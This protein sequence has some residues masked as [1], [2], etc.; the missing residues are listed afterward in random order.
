MAQNIGTLLGAPIRPADSLDAFPS[1]YAN[2]GKGGFY[3]VADLTARNAI[4]ADRREIGMCVKVISENKDYELLRGITNDNW[5]EKIYG[6]DT[7][8]LAPINNPTFTGSVIVPT[9]TTA[10]QAVNFGQLE[11]TAIPY[12]GTP[13]GKPITGDLEFETGTIIK[14]YDAGE[15]KTKQIYF[16]D[17]FLEFS[18]NDDANVCGFFFE[19]D[20]IRIGGTSPTHVGIGSNQDFSPNITDLDYTQKIYVDTAVTDNISGLAGLVEFY[21]NKNQ[22]NG[23]CGLDSGGKVPIENLPTTLLKYQGVWNASTNTP[24]LTNPDLTKVGNVY[25]VS[26]A[27]TQFGITFGLGD[28]LIYNASGVPEKSDNSD[29]VVS[30]N[31]QTGVVTITKSDVGLSNVDNT[32][33]LDKPISTATQNAI[34]VAAQWTKT[35]DNIRNNNVGDVELKMATGKKVSFLNNSNTEV[36]NISQDGS[37]N[38]GNGT[39]RAGSNGFKIGDGFW[40]IDREGL[41]DAGAMRFVGREA[42]VTLREIFKFVSLNGRQYFNVDSNSNF[43][44][45]GNI[46]IDVPPPTDLVAVV[47][48]T[49]G[50]IGAGTRT[51]RVTSLNANGESTA[52]LSIV[53]ATTTGSTNSIALSWTAV[54]GATSYRIY[55]VLGGFYFTS[56][57]NSFTDIGSAGTTG[58]VP[59]TNT[60]VAISL[61]NNGK[62]IIPPATAPNEA[63]NLSQLQ[64]ERHV[65]R[66]HD[67]L[68]VNGDV[69]FAIASV[70]GGGIFANNVNATPNNPGIGRMQSFTNA[71]SGVAVRSSGNSVVIKGL[72]VF[73][74]IF[75]PVNFATT[76]FR[77][78]IHDSIT[79]ADASNGVYFQYVNSSTL[80]FVTANNNVRTTTTI[81]TLS[82]NTWYKVR[83]TVNANAT[84]ILAELFDNVGVLVTS[85]THT[86][87]IPTTARLLN[88]CAIATNSL[89]VLTPMLDIDF[90]DLD[91]TLIR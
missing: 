79:N 72:E 90:I 14:S 78:G 33:D 37:Y 10:N 9:A 20:A 1:F 7:S 71:N 62:V 61:L 11:N 76:I 6:G 66:V 5:I 50:T 85:I 42:G 68:T 16:G 27:G 74:G 55:N 65:Y 82:L 21:H 57:T 59:T 80:Q 2:E 60:A 84:S 88:I 87:N 22:N 13:T 43:N 4:T 28:W 38:A 86:T 23:Y 34:N 30:V 29:D 8:G 36:G 17:N 45:Y 63:V 58:T 24:T 32:S 91:Q 39:V 25:N 73:N 40:S 18:V 54:L 52:S 46:I 3:S 35:G 51:Y 47:S 26:V 75:A 12:T 67:F 77:I 15:N 41:G 69:N 89:T 48:S 70:A 44:V 81:S 64:N 56:S 31:G 49:G 53:G 83:F 19:L